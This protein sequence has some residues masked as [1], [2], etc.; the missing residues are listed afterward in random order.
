MTL[1]RCVPQPRAQPLCVQK[2]PTRFFL[3]TPAS[4]AA[5]ARA[6]FHPEPRE[7]PAGRTWW[8][9]MRLAPLQSTTMGLQLPEPARIGPQTGHALSLRIA[10]RCSLARP[11]PMTRQARARDVTRVSQ[12]CAELLACAAH[13]A[14]RA[15]HGPLGW[16]RR[17]WLW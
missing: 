13:Q 2:Q 10:Y 11:A 7:A 17:R 6:G 12:L 8:R 5:S 15:S 16:A 3:S 1:Q 4:P 14:A 9:M